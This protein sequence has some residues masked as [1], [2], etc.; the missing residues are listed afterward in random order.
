MINIAVNGEDRQVEKE[1]TIEA[2]LQTLKLNSQRVVVELNGEPLMR[3]QYSKT[4]LKDNDKLEIVR[5]VAG[6]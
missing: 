5:A 1:T 4:I 6:G 2:L 3:D